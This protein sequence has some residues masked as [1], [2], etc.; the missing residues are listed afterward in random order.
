[1]SNRAKET[2]MKRR[3]WIRLCA[4]TLAAGAVAPS[5]W[6]QEKMVWKA[7]DVH[8]P[9]YPTVEAMMRMGKK[10][11][12]QTNGRIS[13]QMFPDAAR[14]REGRSSRRRWAQI[15]RISVGAMGRWSTSSTSTCVH[16]LGQAPCADRRSDRRRAARQDHRQCEHLASWRWVD[17]CRHAQRLNVPVS[18]PR[19]WGMKV[20]MMG[21]RLRRDHE[22]Y[23]RQRRGDGVQR[24]YSVPQ[25]GV[26]EGARKTSPP[27]AGAEP[28]GREGLQLTGPSSSR[29]LRLLE[30]HVDTL[31]NDDQALV[32]KPREADRAAPALG[33]EDL[34]A[35]NELKGRASVVAAAKPAFYKATQPIRDKY[36]KVH[37]AAS[38]SDTSRRRR[39]SF[40]L[41][42]TGNKGTPQPLDVDLNREECGRRSSY[43]QSMGGSSP[44]SAWRAWSCW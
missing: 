19:T 13:I 2:L 20:R 15:A 35:T 40:C 43:V 28:P 37:G 12:T 10:L 9:G 24:L 14:W 36:G 33:R 4:S 44:A 39:K 32:K 34:K 27:P 30:A 16:L 21:N 25:T 42:P 3:D 29:D 8:P 31:S 5:A 38:A 6:A 23:G 11:E 22:R 17:G 26:V 41:L 7:S 18:K 1:M